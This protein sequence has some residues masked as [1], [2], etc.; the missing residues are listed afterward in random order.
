MNIVNNLN[1]RKT[2]TYLTYLSEHI[3]LCAMEISKI[4]DILLVINHIPIYT[5]SRC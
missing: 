2:F 3:H 4:D 1:K 5:E